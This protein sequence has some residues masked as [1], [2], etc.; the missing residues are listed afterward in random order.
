VADVTFALVDPAVV[1]ARRAVACIF[2]LNGF[3]YA[4]VVPR[5]P[6]IKSDLG[7]SNTSLG[8]AVAA[9]PVGAVLAGAVAGTMVNRLGSGRVAVGCGVAIGLALPGFAAVPSWGALAMTFFV[10]GA[11]DSVMDVAMNAHGLRV[12]RSYGR[13]IINSMHGVWSIGAV[14]GALVGAATIATGASVGAHLVGA[15]LALVAASL[16]LTRWLLPGVDPPAAEVPT[17]PDGAQPRS[18]RATATR[19]LLAVGCLVLLAG[20]I[21]D[22]PASWGAVFLRTEVEASAV[23]AGLAFVA[24]QASMTVARLVGDRVVDRHGNVRVIRWGGAL[25]AGSMS[26][27]LIV[28]TPAAV[29]AGFMVA[30]VGA[31]PLFPLVFHASAEVPGVS[32]GHGLAVAAL[33]GRIGFLVSPPLIGI[34][35]DVF[36]L[37]SGLALMPVAGAIVALAAPVL[38]TREPPEAARQPPLP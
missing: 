24:F 15:G 6:A 26:A 29:I 27:G 36:S 34:L 31:A 37:R 19:R 18:R 35:G 10:V 9:M 20:A 16:A 4:N 22:A 23:V 30:G 8:T 5:L 1:R 7:L 14:S 21:E 2:A 11:V 28:D 33:M 13:S 38:A 25:I 3:A 12:Q 17:A 32:S